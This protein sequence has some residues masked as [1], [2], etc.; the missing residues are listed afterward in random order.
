M[1][2]FD[3]RG[4]FRA[5]N[6]AKKT[7]VV[8]LGVLGLPLLVAGSL[9]LAY[10]VRGLPSL[11]QLEH[12]EPTLVTKIYS[13]D[14]VL[15]REL[16]IERRDL[17]PLEQIPDYLKYAIIDIE[18]KRFWKHWGLDLR[19]IVRAAFVDIIHMAKLQGASTLTQ[20]LARELY[21]TKEKSFTRKIRETITAIQIERTY[22]KS[23]ILEMYLNH[24]YFGHGAYGVKE[25]ARFYFG[26]DVQD[27]TLEECALLAALPRSPYQYSPIRFPERALRRRNLV[28]RFMYKN[29]HITEEQYKEA[30]QKPLVLRE[31]RSEGKYGIAP[32]F[33]EYVRR[34]LDEKYGQDLYTAGFTIYTTLD[35]RVQACAERAVREFLPQLQKRV[36]KHLLRSGL[37]NRMLLKEYGDAR[38]VQQILADSAAVDSVARVKTA[39]Q[40]ALVA[41]NPQNGHILAMIGGRDFEETQFNRAVQARRQPGSAFK[42][43]IYA[44]A[45][46]NGYPPTYEIL[47]QPLVVF[48]PDSTRWIPQNYDRTQGGP[49][50]LREALRKSLNLVTARLLQKEVTPQEV[51]KYAH[52][53][54]ITTPLRA[55]ASLALGTSEVIPLEI[56]AA[57]SVFANQGVYVK[58]MAI[59]KVVDR[60]GRV[61]E[62]HIPEKQEVLSKQT[63]Y[64]IT[65]MLQTVIDQGTGY[66]ARTV[67][68]F[69]RPAAGKTGTTD[70]FTDAWFIGFTPQIAAGVW[71]GLDDPSLNLGPGQA[72]AVAALPIWALFMKAAHDTLNLPIADFSMPEGV[73][74]LQICMESKKLA[75]EYCPNV[76]EEVFNVEYQPTETCPL[77]TGEIE[78][79]TQRKRR[80]RVLF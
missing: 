10:I 75:T 24:I 9:Y 78:R 38:L 37:L 5:W 66:T 45:I 42:P 7:R 53:M 57:Y 49:T 60:T 55:V 6:G 67:Y 58:P 74:R 50:T 69:Y 48:L 26:K 54:G 2:Q 34:I 33:T 56:T 65:D 70:E 25:A 80:D 15:L 27:L 36:T 19:R 29:G 72:G 76:V 8:F 51:I 46:D 39:V 47:N 21:L 59:L 28:L 64:I 32:Y 11:T 20:Q 35:T 40:V 30:I 62:E 16:F 77:H 71:V 22:S 61:V 3:E 79:P 14:G 23:E 41:L 17:V 13:A 73:V 43:F 1:R 31:G 44:V 63:A 4:F 12:Y 52:N 68:H 18:D